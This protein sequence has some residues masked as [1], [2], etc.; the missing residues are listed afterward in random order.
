V[1]IVEHDRS[2]LEGNLPEEIMETLFENEDEDI[3]IVSF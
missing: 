2:I 1:G 3:E